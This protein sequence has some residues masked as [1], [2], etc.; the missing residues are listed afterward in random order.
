[1]AG[2]LWQDAISKV[3]MTEQVKEVVKKSA[4]EELAA[5]ELEF[6]KLEIEAKKAEFQDIQERL[7]ERKVKRENKESRSK[8]N[9]TTLRQIAANDALIQSKCNHRKGGN[10]IEGVVGGQG[11]DPQFALIKHRFANGDIWCRCQRCGKTYKPPLEDDYY[12]NDKGDKVEPKHGTFSKET[13]QKAEEEYKWALAAPTRNVMSSG[14]SYSF[15]DGGVD[16]RKKM[17]S[18]NLR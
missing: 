15:S 2:I 10:G 5:A 16:Y 3:N 13:F 18:T 11:D 4:V 12:F 9:G 6:K 7:L 1:M 8:V 17:R 14:F